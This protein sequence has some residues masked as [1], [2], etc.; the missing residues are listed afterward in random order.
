MPREDF[1]DEY[2]SVRQSSF[3]KSTI[4]SAFRKSGM[5]PINRDVFTDND[6]VP[7]VPYSTEAQDFPSLPTE[8]VSLREMEFNPNSSDSDSD[9]DPDFDLGSK[10]DS[11]SDG[12]ESDL[13]THSNSP[14]AHASS[15]GIPTQQF[16]YDPVIFACI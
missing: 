16:Y 1:I 13:E 5:W 12:S 14:T 10:S 2:M 9:M 4:M 6:F 3:S 11:D 15:S 7:S 8:L